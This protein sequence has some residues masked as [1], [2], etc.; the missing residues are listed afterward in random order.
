MAST[1]PGF[2]GMVITENFT[3]Y[4]HGPD[5]TPCWVLSHR[6]S[7]AKIASNET[8]FSGHIF[9]AWETS[10]FVLADLFQAVCT[11]MSTA[12]LQM[13]LVSHLL[14][15]RSAIPSLFLLRPG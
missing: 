9:E 1:I 15:P 6:W 5:Q 3:D 8:V 14:P 7:F 2:H 4:M 12:G 13:A 10:K 11:P